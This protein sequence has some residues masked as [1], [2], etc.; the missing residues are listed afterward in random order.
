MNDR[1]LIQFPGLGSYIP[2]I[3]AGMVE[4]A[5]PLGAVVSEIDRVAAAY[6]LGPVSQPLTD[7][8]GPDIESLAE[9]PTLLHLA[10]FAS[11][12]V[13]YRALCTRGVAGDVLLGHSTGEITALAAGGA[14][15]VSDAARVLCE[16]EVAL[17]DIG[18]RGGLVAVHTSAKRAQQLCGAAGG[19]SLLVSLSNSPGQAVISGSEAD[20]P[21][22]EAVTQAAGVQATRLL[23]RYPHHNPLLRPAAQQVAAAAATYRIGDPTTRVYSPILGRF[24][25][26]AADARRIVDRHLTEAVDYLGAIRALYDDFELREFIEVGVRSVLTDRTGESLPPDVTLRSPPANA[27]NAHQILDVLAGVSGPDVLSS[28]AVP[29]ATDPEPAADSGAVSGGPATDG[30]ASHAL[31]DRDVLLARLRRTFA[32][33][34]GYPEDVFTDDAHLEADLGIASVKKTEL[35]VR[36]LDE[37]QLPTPP[38]QLRMRDYSTL[39]KLAGL[40]ETLATQQAV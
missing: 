32:E 27:R 28:A 14:L 24:V 37:Y 31:P 2:G 4:A 39:P 22:L 17:A 12:Y 3:L 16:R 19:W 15:S 11:S 35:V 5:P 36:L 30:F 8:A 25:A 13:L 40:M 1:V 23:V 21:R 34:L 26:D 6:G 18:E 29:S 9:T 38:A 20:L 10:S 33:A 7:P